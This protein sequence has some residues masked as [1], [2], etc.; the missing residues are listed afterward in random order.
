MICI[1]NAFFQP[2]K[3]N[4][5]STVPPTF[6]NTEIASLWKVHFY[7]LNFLETFLVSV[8]CLKIKMVHLNF[9]EVPATPLAQSV[10]ASYL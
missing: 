3:S 1:M 10:S 7:S 4:S 6:H 9:R 5:S 8:F 2:L